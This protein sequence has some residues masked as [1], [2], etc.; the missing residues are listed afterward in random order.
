M[1]CYG[2]FMDPG[3]RGISVGRDLILGVRG[4]LSTR[5]VRAGGSVT[6]FSAGY[7]Y[8]NITAARNDIDLTY[9]GFYGTATAGTNIG[10]GRRE[11]QVRPRSGV[12]LAEDRPGHGRAVR[13]ARRRRE[14]R[15]GGHRDDRPDVRKLDDGRLG[16]GIETV[17]STT[18][19]RVGSVTRRYSIE[20]S[21]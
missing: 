19:E 20:V 21:R 16:W 14:G 1:I 7:V 5:Y 2:N 10:L 13:H 18:T 4:M 9:N 17:I 6:L 11:A 8:S 15:R 3:G 12:G